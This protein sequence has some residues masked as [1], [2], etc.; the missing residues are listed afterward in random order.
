MWVWVGVHIQKFRQLTNISWFLPSLSTGHPISLWNDDG[1]R[2]IQSLLCVHAS[3]CICSDF[4]TPRNIQLIIKV[5]LWLL[6]PLDVSV[7]IS[8]FSVHWTSQYHICNIDLPWRLP[9]MI[10]IIFNSVPWPKSFPGSSPNQTFK[11]NTAFKKQRSWYLV[12][13]LHDK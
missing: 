5:H 9:T 11:L 8:G 1:W 7:N 4:Q 3:L 10:M 12:P 2:T 13:S 6:H